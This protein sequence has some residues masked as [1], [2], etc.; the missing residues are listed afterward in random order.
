MKTP[1]CNL[2]LILRRENPAGKD[3]GIQDEEWILFGSNIVL[4]PSYSSQLIVSE[5]NVHL[6]PKLTIDVV[7]YLNLVSNH[8]HEI[9]S[10]SAWE[11]V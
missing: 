3:C 8:D 10:S 2:Y 5:Y 1:S 4:L 7:V 6:H 9:V 11:A